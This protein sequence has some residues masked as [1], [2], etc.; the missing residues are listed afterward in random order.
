[1]P[2][3]K[4]IEPTRLKRLRA[5]PLLIMEWMTDSEGAIQRVSATI[6]QFTGIDGDRLRGADWLQTVHPDDR[7]SSI[8]SVLA[9]HQRQQASL[10]SFRV[11]RHDG[12]HVQTVQLGIPRH[13]KDGRFQGHKGFGF[14]VDRKF[15]DG[16]YVPADADLRSRIIDA[17]PFLT[18]YMDGN[19]IYR[20]VNR[21]YAGFWNLS[22]EGIVGMSVQEVTGALYERVCHGL[23]TALTG[24]AKSYQ[25]NVQDMETESSWLDITHLPET[26]DA[27]RVTGVYCFVTDVTRLHEREALLQLVLNHAPAKILLLDLVGRIR[28]A[29]D[30]L[31]AALGKHESADLGQPWSDWFQ[32]AI[33]T[34]F[35]KEFQ[36]ALAGEERRFE[37]RMRTAAKGEIDVLVNL[38]PHFAADREIT[39]V[40]ALIIDTSDLKQTQRELRRSQDRYELAVRASAVAVW[41]YELGGGD[42]METAEIERLLGYAPGELQNSRK[43]VR[44]LIHPEDQPVNEMAVRLCSHGIGTQEELRFRTCSGDYRW[45]S[46][47]SHVVTDANGQP[48]RISGTLTDVHALKMAQLQTA[49]QVR[50]RDQFLAMLSHEL[51]N[52]MTAIVFALNCIET[53]PRLDPSLKDMV[54]I[55]SRQST[56]LTHLLSDLLDVGRIVNNRITFEMK[57][58]DFRNIVNDVLSSVEARFSEKDQSFQ[59]CLPRTPLWIHADAVRIRQVVAN[60]LDNAHK[61]TPSGGRIELRIRE[62]DGWLEFSVTDSGMGIESESLEHIFDLFF[63]AEQ[64]L[65][66]E[67]GGMGVGL[68]L[69][70]R[71]L[72]F[73]RGR[74]EVQSEGRDRG[75]CFRFEL[76]LVTEPETEG[77]CTEKRPR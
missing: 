53:S 11:R 40:C 6:E 76:P 42:R 1:M 15:A 77:S 58:L 31:I 13:D 61:Y 20:Q 70:K 72:E 21:K 33:R 59:V 51:R 66:R 47:R 5:E 64:R 45:Y 8:R 24:V 23:N 7:L 41:E 32:G 54:Q 36:R 29:N 19:L 74:I 55:I 28:Y 56:H 2:S 22:C 39:S 46:D 38:V 71:I 37:T 25:L 34:T 63:Q 75:S 67:S 50:R 69:A 68:Y 3:T 43:R 35:P 12:Q 18:S 65:D 73:H 10:F 14:P 27:G 9:T 4:G 44:E 30:S 62:I 49:E 26:D 48:T 60:L 16:P 17:A 52:P 57:T